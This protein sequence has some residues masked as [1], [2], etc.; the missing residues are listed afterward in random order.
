MIPQTL[1]N[2][3]FLSVPRTLDDQSIL[4]EYAD[5]VN[6]STALDDHEIV[7]TL[8]YFADRP[9]APASP[10][11]RVF[12]VDLVDAG[13]GLSDYQYTRGARNR[14]TLS[15]NVYARTTAALPADD[16][17]HDYLSALQ[18]WALRD[19]PEILDVVDLTGVI[20]LTDQDGTSRRGIDLIVRYPLTWTDTVTTIDDVQEEVSVE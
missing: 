17:L 11:N 7:V 13:E 19:L 8:R 15:L 2:Q 18:V 6:V 1:K 14:T 12:S 5:R 16:V 10:L 4:V 3:V 20:D 9:D